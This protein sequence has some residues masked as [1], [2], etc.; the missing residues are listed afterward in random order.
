[1]HF[2]G[3]IASLVC[4]HNIKEHSDD[5]SKFNDPFKRFSRVPKKPSLAKAKRNGSSVL[6]TELSK[7]TTLSGAGMMKARALQTESNM[8]LAQKICAP[9]TSPTL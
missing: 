6:S 1:M 4:D 8:V 3:F 5:V 2:G 9:K 7:S